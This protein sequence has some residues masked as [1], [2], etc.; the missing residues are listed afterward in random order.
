MPGVPQRL[1][2]PTMAAPRLLVG[3]NGSTN[4]EDAL[5]L[6][7]TLYRAIGAELLLARVIP[8]DPCPLVAR[9]VPCPVVAVPGTPEREP[10]GAPS[11]KAGEPA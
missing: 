2:M 3:Y 4:A 10:G 7:K 5:T 8:R 11:T 1:I 9:A 6:R